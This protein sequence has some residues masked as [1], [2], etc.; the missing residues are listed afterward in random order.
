MP[1]S[2]RY[3]FAAAALLVGLWVLYPVW[4]AL[5]LAALLYLMLEPVVARMQA[6]QVPQARAI[7]LALL[8][9]LLILG[10]AATYGFNALRGYLPQL[11]ADL[12]Y[13]QAG[14]VRALI[15][16]ETFL[17]SSIPI[18]A[19][20]SAQLAAIDINAAI[21]LDQLLESSSV[22]AQ[23][24][25]NFALV[26]PLAFFILR[27]FHTVRDRFINLLPNRH[28]E[29]GWLIYN[30]V[31]N[32]LQ[33]YLRGLLLQQLI[34]ATITGTG[35]WLAGF[36]SPVLL[37]VLT[38]VAGLVPYLGPLLA[39]VAPLV[40]VLGDTG[41]AT[42]DIWQAVMVLAVGFGFDNL[43]VIP[44]LLAGT[45][46]IHPAVALVAV[47][48]AGHFAGIPGMIL[49]IPLLGMA[50]I[51]TESIYHGLRPASVASR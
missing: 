48:I 19:P 41:M 14:A 40:I 8:P 12:A 37:G 39:M 22:V 13:L 27:D 3:L 44:F 46:N 31:S 21:D 1:S 16:I 49:V 47:V 4:L 42:A 28:F 36:P 32:R 43:V 51:V 18:S 6:R 5:F 50:R 24:A 25:I 9:P 20:L 35:F 2:V 26:P 15:D 10:W 23:L 11:P 45:V 29:L 33:A 34:L 38:G 17:S 7:A 30:R